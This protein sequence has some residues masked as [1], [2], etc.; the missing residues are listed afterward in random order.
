MENVNAP[1][2]VCFDLLVGTVE[3]KKNSKACTIECKHTQYFSHIV[4]V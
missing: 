2:K 4:H 1:Q 3:M